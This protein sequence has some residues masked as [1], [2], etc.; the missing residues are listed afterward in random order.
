[1]TLTC[2]ALLAVAGLTALPT[3]IGC[4]DH[5][6]APTDETPGFTQAEYYPIGLGRTWRYVLFEEV[7]SGGR[8]T[9]AIRIEAQTTDGWRNAV[10][11]CWLEGIGSCTTESVSPDSVVESGYPFPDRL[12]FRFPMRDGDRWV[13]RDVPD[14]G[15]YGGR[16]D[17]WRE[18]AAVTRLDSLKLRTGAVFAGVLRIDESQVYFPPHAPAETTRT[19]TRYLARDVGLVCVRSFASNETLLVSHEL[20]GHAAGNGSNA[21]AAVDS[22]SAMAEGVHVRLRWENPADS[23]FE[24]VLIRYGRDGYP[25]RPEDGNP[26]ANGNRGHFLGTPA[27]PDSF[28]IS[29]LEPATTYYFSAFAYDHALEYAIP[30]CA[31]A[32]TGAPAPPDFLPRTSPANLLL[33]LM[34]AY[35]LR[36]V[37]EYESLLASPDFAFVLSEEDQGKPGMPDSWG[38]DPEVSIH[39]HMF[40]AGMVRQLTLDFH[41]GDVIWDATQGM[42][43]VLIYNV[44]LY[45]YGATPGHPT[46]VKEY[47]VRGSRSKF[48]FRKN[49]WTTGAAHDSVWTIVRWE[50]VPYGSLSAAPAAGEPATWGALKA[51]YR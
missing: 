26:V 34:A 27:T 23:D 8:D 20:L 4:G 19:C 39:R 41:L 18:I 36:N 32:T 31:S 38:R 10:T 46:E 25:A 28:L 5:E 9:V 50:D 14:S 43:T 37:A 51:I 44:N 47:R 1:V 13:V 33:N 29:G 24:G 22:F 2:A 45:L 12:K 35:Q 11:L 40:D 48:W 49:A 42:Y 16:L 17:A 21:P 7:P 30:A 15:G 3:L 6:S